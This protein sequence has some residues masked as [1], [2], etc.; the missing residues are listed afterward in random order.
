M[1]LTGSSRKIDTTD[2]QIT[3]ARVGTIKG[4]VIDDDM[5]KIL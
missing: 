5:G 1:R 4:E 2:Q 3:I